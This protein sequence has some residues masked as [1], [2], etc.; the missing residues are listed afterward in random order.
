[1][2]FVWRQKRASLGLLLFSRALGKQLL[3]E[4]LLSEPRVLGL[5]PSTE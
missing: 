3:A 5:I 4:C 1:M 2:L